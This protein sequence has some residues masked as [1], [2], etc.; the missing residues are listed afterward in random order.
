MEQQQQILLAAA[1]LALI[2][3]TAL[4]VRKVRDR[5]RRD[6]ARKL[7]TV[8]KQKETVTVICSQK[9]G[10]WILTN[11]RLLL[12]TPEGFTE[13]PFSKIKK[14]QGDTAEGKK[15]T[16]P[17]RMVNLTVTARDTEYTLQ[18]NSPEFMEL[19]K[20]LKKKLPK[21]SSKKKS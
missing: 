13:I 8:L 17:S 6:F 19:A 21:K 1:A 2:L 9:Q 11:K 20:E 5:R 15:T 7:E 12:D 18:G 16:V 14:F 10:R 4:Q 3:W